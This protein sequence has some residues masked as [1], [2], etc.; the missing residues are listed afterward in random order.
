MVMM[1]L[2]YPT[3]TGYYEQVYNN[4]TTNVTAKLTKTRN[5]PCR[6]FA[7]DPTIENDLGKIYTHYEALNIPSVMKVADASVS[8]VRYKYPVTGPTST[9]PK[10]DKLRFNVDLA[11]IGQ[12][13]YGPTINKD[14]ALFE[15]NKDTVVA[16]KQ[17]I[18]INF[19]ANLDRSIK[20]IEEV[21]DFDINDFIA[22]CSAIFNLSL[23]LLAFVF[24]TRL[25][26]DRYFMFGKVGKLRAFGQMDVRATDFRQKPETGHTK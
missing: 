4:Q 8:A 2:Q 12:C 23:A 10:V 17:L 7:F 3:S 14:C 18:A 5:S 26:L 15:S 9:P 25:A 11:V 24:P 20:I 1:T 19:K 6:L 13:T 22:N 16:V 21:T